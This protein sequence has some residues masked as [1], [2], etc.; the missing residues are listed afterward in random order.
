MSYIYQFRLSVIK[1]IPERDFGIREAAKLI[2]FP[3][4]LSL[5]G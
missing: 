1:R 3:I 2:I 4:V 5:T